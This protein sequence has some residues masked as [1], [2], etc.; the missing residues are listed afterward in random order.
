MNVNHLLETMR[1]KGTVICRLPDSGS[2]GMFSRPEQILEA[3]SPES[4]K[5]VLH[6]LE[7][8]LNAG[9]YAAGFISYEAAGAFDR[10][11][12]VHASTEFP[13]VWMG[14]YHA[15][16]VE[17]DLTND[18]HAW[19]GKLTSELTERE[20]LDRI[21]E[22]KDAID[23]GNI[24]QANYTFRSRGK[25]V[26][27]PERLFLALSAKHPMPYSA[28]VNCGEYQILSLSPELF[29]EKRGRKIVSC[30][31][32]GTIHRDAEPELDRR[33]S[34][35][36]QSDPK[37]RAENLMIVDM[38]RNDLGRI[39]IPGSITANPLFQVDTYATL[40]QMIST[41]CGELP[42]DISI[43]QILQATF[44]A[45]S[46]T[47]APKVAAMR[48]ILS[49]ETSPRK[50]YTGT[51]G[52][53]MADNNFCLNVA[54]RTLICSDDCT[55]LGIG[56][57]IVCDSQAEM[58]WA[59][60][61]LKS[62]FIESCA[63]EFYVLETMLWDGSKIKYLA[64]HLKRAERSQHYFER[65]WD[66]RKTA[67]IVANA[68]SECL[69]RKY[70][71]A[72]IRLRFD[73]SGN[74]LME[75]H[76]LLEQG[77]SDYPRIKVCDEHTCSHDIFLYH[78]TDCRDLYNRKFKQGQ[79]EGFDEIVFFNERDELTEGAISNV[80]VSINGHWFT[81]PVTCGLLHGIWRD[82]MLV[83]LMAEEKIIRRNDLKLA[84][85]IIIGNS[86]RGSALIKQISGI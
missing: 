22:I 24:Y 37:N 43:T 2:W 55:E 44:P 36:L 69:S 66:A 17:I 58:E 86:V 15:A 50:V 38:V 32:K 73:C 54:I 45:A 49:H 81:P 80:F 46:I 53:F 33:H 51:I 75:L 9:K 25:S 61:L 6:Q 20:Y 16:P 48:V 28:F 35:F 3:W 5:D 57:G 84:E 47:G 34:A 85:K 67:A 83:E 4:V 10:A 42:E 79:K 68:E 40:H 8:S 18:I 31:M 52:C 21:A 13:V 19:C 60:A 7:D 78:K 56:G 82:K 77:W 65:A 76:P 27:A 64:E 62:R 41:V 72:R 39:C 59:E 23:A 11:L 14:I 29:L 71:H 1:H 12:E 26:L 74:I 30:P 63:P 70:T